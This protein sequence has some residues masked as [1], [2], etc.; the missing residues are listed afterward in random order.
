[1]QHGK[2]ITMNHDGGIHHTS[3]P[4]SGD[5]AVVATPAQG[6]PNSKKL[7]KMLQTV[8]DGAQFRL[9]SACCAP[10]IGWVLQTLWH[11]RSSSAI[12]TTI[13]M[14]YHCSCQQQE[15]EEQGQDHAVWQ[16]PLEHLDSP[17]QHMTCKLLCCGQVCNRWCIRRAQVRCWSQHVR[18]AAHLTVP[19]LLL[20]DSYITVLLVRIH[21]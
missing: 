18:A 4:P 5:S 11:S 8:L 3:N 21:P 15:A 2:A 17:D 16:V 10:S 13:T 9:R 12:S 20:V 19:M 6:R 1:M 7:S 14:L